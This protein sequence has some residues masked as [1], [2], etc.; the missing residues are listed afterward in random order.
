M[1]KIKNILLIGYG[2]I[3]K[4]HIKALNK[5]NFKKNIFILSNRKQK[6]KNF[7]S[8]LDIKKINPDYIIVCSETH[9]HIKNLNLIEKNLTNKLILLEKQIG[10]ASCRERV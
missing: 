2:S 10:R 7:I 4:K 3:A 9:H 8:T 6:G 5:L 1:F